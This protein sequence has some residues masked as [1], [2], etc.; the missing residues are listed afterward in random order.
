MAK[1]K[2]Y[3]LM[4]IFDSQGDEAEIHREFDVVQSLVEKR[5]TEFIGRADWGLKEFKY[6]IT[7]RNSGYYVYFLF[8]AEIDTPVQLAHALKMNEKILR[9]MI[10]AGNSRSVEYLNKL[11]SEPIHK[12]EHTE[13]VEP[14]KE[15]LPIIEK[16]V[17]PPVENET[18]EVSKEEET[19]DVVEPSTETASEITS[20][21]E[22]SNEPSAEIEETV[23]IQEEIKED[24]EVV[25]EQ[26]QS[27]ENN[28]SDENEDNN[29]IE[30]QKEI[31][32]IENDGA[33]KKSEE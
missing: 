2:I 9:H 13:P 30:E 29:R 12:I 3:E 19:Q 31:G 33:E 27:D 20:E 4:V 15:E 22:P 23:E 26:E 11:H 5:S 6:P 14:V 28:E 7:K 10:I 8:K 25:R 17:E 32:G 24:P 16:A 1:E 18:I 21:S